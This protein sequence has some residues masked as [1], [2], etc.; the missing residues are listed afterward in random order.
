MSSSLHYPKHLWLSMCT[1]SYY[2]YSHVSLQDICTVTWPNAGHCKI[3]RNPSG[4]GENDAIATEVKPR[5]LLCHLRLQN[6][7]KV[8]LCSVPTVGGKRT[9]KDRPARYTLKVVTNWPISQRYKWTV[10]EGP[11]GL[12]TV[13][14]NR[15]NV[16][17]W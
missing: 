16:R 3:I 2:T 11:M 8:V 12:A 10:D 17:Q 1:S 13:T 7:S 4:R 6:Y 9:L 15:Q 5:L 14:V